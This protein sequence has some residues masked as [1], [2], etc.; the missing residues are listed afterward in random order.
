MTKSGTNDYHFG[1]FFEYTNSDLRGTKVADRPVVSIKP[2]KRWGAYL[3][4]PIIK[5]RLFI[6]GAY[7][8]QEAGQSQDEGPNGGGF[9]TETPGVSVDQFNEITQVLRDVY[10]IDSV[11]LVRNGPFRNDR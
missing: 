2:D 7:E 4:G 6:Y 3:G 8:H 5:D 1:G 9:T 11:P 10:G